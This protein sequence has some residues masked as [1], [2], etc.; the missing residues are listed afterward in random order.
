MWTPALHC[1]SE[2]VDLAQPAPCA[3]A[4]D[5]WAAGLVE[6]AA[7]RLSWVAG[8]ND[9]VPTQLLRPALLS[10]AVEYNVTSIVSEGLGRFRSYISGSGDHG[11]T[12]NTRVVAFEA[13]VR[14]LSENEGYDR[15][16]G[17]YLSSTD[18][19][20]R[21]AA[22]NALALTPDRSVAQA[23]LDFSLSEEV[24]KQ[25]APT[26][27]SRIAAVYNSRDLVWDFFKEKFDE[28]DSRYGSGGFAIEKLVANAAGRFMSDAKY[29]DI[30]VCGQCSIHSPLLTRN[31]QSFFKSHPLPAAAR[32]VSQALESIRASA[33]WRSS[34]A[35][36]LC[37][38]F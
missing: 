19:A 8:I 9:T 32:Q 2:L 13:A 20:E 7:E 31:A 29:S 34:M 18:P 5:A 30:E 17:I 35:D 27:I 6:V 21:T 38:M 37:D 3:E 28:F 14:W 36:T 24:R 4:A 26:L 10:A 12:P 16:K 25:D 1:I 33:D 23:L 15:V 22:L 11:L